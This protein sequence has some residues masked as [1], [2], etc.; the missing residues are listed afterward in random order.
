MKTLLLIFLLTPLFALSQ[1]GQV[2][3]AKN[4]NGDTAHVYPNDGWFKPIFYQTNNGRKIDTTTISGLF[5]KPIEKKKA[6]WLKEYTV[7]IKDEHQVLL[8]SET[9][10]V[11]LL[12]ENATVL[13][14]ERIIFTSLRNT[15]YLN[16]LFPRWLVT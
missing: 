15:L 13:S 1:I 2:I 3:K 14:E 16:N 8:V 7:T 11:R 6:K 10:T 12:L 4:A 5:A 9:D